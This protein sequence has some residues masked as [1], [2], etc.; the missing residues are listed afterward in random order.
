MHFGVFSSRFLFCMLLF[1]RVLWFF[2]FQLFTYIRFWGGERDHIVCGE[3][4]VFDLGVFVYH[5]GDEGIMFHM[6]LEFT[7]ICF[8]GFWD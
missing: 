3:L 6:F 8:E 1:L 2:V 5:S 4:R 7:V